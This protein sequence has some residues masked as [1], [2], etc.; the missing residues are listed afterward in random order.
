MLLLL[1]RRS[2]YLLSSSCGIGLINQKR[3]F[4]GAINFAS[5]SSSHVV[6]SVRF[7]SSS[8]PTNNNNNNNA[9]SLT[10][11]QYQICPYCNKVKALLNYLNVN[12]TT[13]EVNPLTKAELKTLP[14]M[15]TATKKEEKPYRKVPIVILGQN[16]TDGKINEEEK[17]KLQQINGSDEIISTLLNHEYIK[18][19]LQNEKWNSKTTEMNMNKFL[20]NASTSSSDS[21]SVVVE[22]EESEEEKNKKKWIE[23][24]NDLSLI[25]YP[26][27]CRTLSD[28]Y[29]TFSY[30]DEEK[31][32][33]QFSTFQRFSIKTIGSLAMYFAASRIKKKY[34]IED[35]R[36]ALLDKIVDMEQAKD[37]LDGGKKKFLVDDENPTQ[38][39][40]QGDDG[41][42][43]L[44]DLS[45]YGVLKSIEHTD[46]FHDVV[47]ER[48]DGE[49]ENG[50]VAI[51]QWY[52]RMK[53][54]VE[55]N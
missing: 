23:F 7:F 24:S 50:D 12:Y 27:I 9:P 33:Q 2:N 32:Q 29:K 20:S 22:E 25:L 30:I 38:E 41:H 40:K 48:K 5:A 19:I 21:T 49:N 1:Q 52:Y 10:L 34:N 16:D 13:V 31:N 11:Y 43:G 44:A 8:L 54:Q 37:G 42:P 17:Q 35:E 51:K 36:K 18:D 6:D 53:D 15:T 45:I 28:S 47:I 14:T 46:A 55:G 4:P 39:G 3:V 26:N